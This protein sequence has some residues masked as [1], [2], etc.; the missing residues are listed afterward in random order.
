[1]VIVGGCG[2]AGSGEAEADSLYAGEG[3]REDP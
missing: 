3:I 1:M 2:E